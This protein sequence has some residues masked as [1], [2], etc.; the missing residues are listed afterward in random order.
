MKRYNVY[1]GTTA[2]IERAGFLFIGGQ[3]KEVDLT[4]EQYKI[5]SKCEMLSVMEIESNYL[6][7][8][9]KVKK[10]DKN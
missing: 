6:P 3:E 1:N 8:K 4:K 5:I 9:K 7:T 10:D 2:S